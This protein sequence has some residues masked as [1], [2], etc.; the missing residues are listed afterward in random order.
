MT[1]TPRPAEREPVKFTW[2]ST[3]H[4]GMCVD[5][6]PPPAFPPLHLGPRPVAAI[7]PPSPILSVP[8]ASGRDAAEVLMARACGGT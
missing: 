8:S 4:W 3:Q 1:P 2:S 5:G 6:K 7:H